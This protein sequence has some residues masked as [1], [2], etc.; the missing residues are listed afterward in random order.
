MSGRSEWVNSWPVVGTSGKTYTVSMN[1]DGSVWGCSCEA[2]KFQRLSFIDRKPCQHILQ[3][4]LELLQHEHKAMAA[5]SPAGTTKV[6][7]TKPVNDASGRRF[8]EDD[9]DADANHQ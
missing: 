6:T 8:R 9:G 3:K 1:A 2:W 4:R 7:T 5:T